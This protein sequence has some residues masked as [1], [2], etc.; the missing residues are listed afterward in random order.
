[1]F[2]RKKKNNLL[3]L[4]AEEIKDEALDVLDWHRRHKKQRQIAWLTGA[5]WV[6]VGLLLVLM[7]NVLMFLPGM[8]KIYWESLSGKSELE[9]AVSL[10]KSGN[11]QEL[12]KASASAQSH[13]AISLKEIRKIKFSPIG[14]LPFSHAKINDGFYLIEAGSLA[15]Q[16]LAD[17]S[18]ELNK[19][20][21]LMPSKR[22]FD[23]SKFDKKQKQAL[24]ELLVGSQKSLKQAKNNLVRAQ[25]DLAKIQNRQ[26]IENQGID[27][28]SLSQKLNDNEKQINKALALAE[29]LPILG[30]YPEPVN[31]LFVLQNSD[32]LRP[33]GGFIGTLGFAHAENGE[34]SN[35]QTK[36]VYH[37]DMP[38]KDKLKVDSPLPLKKYL[39][40]NNWYLRDA[41]WSPDWPTSAEKIAWFYTEENKLLPQ[42]NNLDNFNLIIGLT[43]QAIIDLLELTGP[44]KANGQVY[45]KNNFMPLL[46]DTTGKD[47]SK[48]GVSSWDRKA[49]IGSI[50]QEMNKK[51]MSDLGKNWQKLL[52][53]LSGNLDQK[54]ILVYTTNQELYAKA[55]AQ[56]WLGEIRETQ[57][58]YLMAVD[59]NLAALKTDAVINR[60]LD[61]VVQETTD[62][63]VAKVKINYAN[64]GNFTWK[65][66]RYRTFT[67]IYVPKGSQLIKVAGFSDDQDS[68]VSGEE[69]NKTYFGAFIEIEPGK[70]GGLSFEYKLPYNLYAL[71][72]KGEY[73]LLLQKQP[74]TKIGQINIDCQFSKAIKTYEP[75]V[76]YSFVN[77]GRFRYKGDFLT[78]KNFSLKF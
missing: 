3:A 8:K 68:V 41:N 43:P 66:T 54:N 20:Q 15:S 53:I 11:W 44:I 10:A 40:V 69:L 4:Y 56:G 2:G 47:F 77:N 35:I 50:T 72:K 19:F 17:S 63:L 5:V 55:Q 7:I 38:V 75:A 6:L 46:Q 49:V 73:S 57:G 52:D 16:A 76:L 34:L 9:K 48:F 25:A 23:I 67:R 65:T 59:A 13:F 45:D 62:G 33:T 21:A 28:D 14:W 12:N 58:D 71:Y 30:G 64:Q 36:D 51:I 42:P 18:A 37:F 70:I 24:M 32:E 22:T 74:G 29:V 31:Y 78:D 1:M 27:L 60:S 61:Y 26:L 39:G